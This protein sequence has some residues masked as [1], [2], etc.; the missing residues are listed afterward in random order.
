MGFTRTWPISAMGDTHTH[1]H[2]HAHRETI[3]VDE[4]IE[5][6]K[7]QGKLKRKEFKD[8]R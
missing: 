2:T 7:I 8:H 3:G 5:D 4:F 1:T 6:L